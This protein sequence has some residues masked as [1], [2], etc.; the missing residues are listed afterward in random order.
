M[1]FFSLVVTIGRAF[2]GRRIGKRIMVEVN[3][4]MFVCEVN[5]EKN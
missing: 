3:L 5:W 1:N 2:V 4:Y